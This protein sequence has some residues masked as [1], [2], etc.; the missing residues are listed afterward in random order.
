MNKNTRA[1]VYI[2]GPLF[3]D[4]E[5]SFNKMLKQQLST[6]FDIYLP[7]E[8]GHL[9]VELVKNGSEPEFASKIVFNRD[10]MEIKECDILLIILD[11]RAVDEGAAFELG[12]AYS[13]GKKCVGLQTDYR[14][15]L[16][17]G[18]NPMIENSLEKI[19][20][21]TEAMLDDM[22]IGRQFPFAAV[23]SI[24]SNEKG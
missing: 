5:R 9:L 21:S 16:P 7:Q 18:N 23:D 19:Y 11:G 20:L 2:A 8:D 14:R 13:L 1:R 12:V 10:V 22:L 6:E 15:L 3:S 17:L 4:A 24:R